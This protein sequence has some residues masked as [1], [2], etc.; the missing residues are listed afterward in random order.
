MAVPFGR[1]Q[2]AGPAGS[3]VESSQAPTPLSPTLRQCFGVPPSVT[4][5]ANR[6]RSCRVANEV[7]LAFIPENQPVCRGMPT[8]VA[9][10]L[11]QSFAW[12]C[13][14]VCRLRL[15]SSALIIPLSTLSFPAQEV[16]QIGLLPLCASTHP[17]SPP[18]RHK[19]YVTTRLRAA[20]ASDEDPYRRR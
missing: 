9:G 7:A 15:I 6:A 12:F 5:R 16:L 19:L 8:A 1:A 10:T 2:I 20:S 4:Q 17:P 11:G 3:Q 13:R 18:N 14:P